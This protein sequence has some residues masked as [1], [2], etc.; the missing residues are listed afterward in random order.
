M[1]AGTLIAGRFEIVGQ[2]GRGGMA[3]VHRAIDHETQGYAALKVLHI[4]MEDAGERFRLRPSTDCE[5][6]YPRE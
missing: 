5:W 6:T 3:Q 1:D 4:T 2:A